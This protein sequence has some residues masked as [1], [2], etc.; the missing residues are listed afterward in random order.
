MISRWSS[1]P[2]IIVEVLAPAVEEL[3]PML[4]ASKTVG[5]KGI[6][7]CKSSLNLG[8]MNFLVIEKLN[9]N[10]LLTAHGKEQNVKR[11]CPSGQDDRFLSE[12]DESTIWYLDYL[13]SSSRVRKGWIQWILRFSTA[14]HRKDI[15]ILRYFRM[16]TLNPQTALNSEPTAKRTSHA[17]RG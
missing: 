2:R 11:T 7:F 5:F 14:A 6:L 15:L 17:S 16:P 3:T 13:F 10:S 1:G 4:G 8:W 12:R 9:D